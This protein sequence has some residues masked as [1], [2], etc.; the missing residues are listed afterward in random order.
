[1]L[2]FPLLLGVGGTGLTA[3]EESGPR[4]PGAASC[5]IEGN[6]SLA[7]NPEARFEFEAELE[8]GT[9]EHEGH[10]SYSDP[11][12]GLRVRATRITSVLVRGIHGTVRGVGQADGAVV[13]FTIEVE[14]G[15][16][17]GRLDHFQIQLSTGYAAAG[18]V[19]DGEVEIECN[20][21]EGD[22]TSGPSRGGRPAFAAGGASATEGPEAD[23]DGPP[24]KRQPRADNLWR[25]LGRDFR[26][27]VDGDNLL[28]FAVGG[29]ASL[30]V[31]GP[32]RAITNSF[33][34]STALDRFLELGEVGGGGLV[35]VGGAI[36]TY[37]VGRA[38]G[39]P[40]VRSLGYDLVRAQVVAGVLTQGL[41]RTTGRRRPDGSDRLSFPSG[42]SSAAFATA[43]VLERHHGWKVG[44]PAYM[45]A[46]YVAGSRLQENKHFPSDVLFGAAVGIV[47]GRSV[48]V[49]RGRARVALVPLA[50]PGGGLGA[51][52][53]GGWR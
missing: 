9:A 52:V 16:A 19:E 12:A 50:V 32:D 23:P 35:Q 7:T 22:G 41:K 14:D 13:T 15:T 40:A 5:E 53:V 42:H 10:V 2:L 45:F 36:A 21:E 43:T 47:G 39:K 31:R 1:M 51:A 24:S 20:D 49:D 17:E 37:V 44:L 28:V 6:G 18:D 38:A 33:E 26:H 34:G 48:T 4:V 46:A 30:T 3:A 27:V 25:R 29:A 8:P 11:R